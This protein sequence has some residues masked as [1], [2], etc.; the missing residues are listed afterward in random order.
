LVG[1]PKF[2]KQ[3]NHILEMV[4]L[5]ETS[6]LQK[7]AIGTTSPSPATT[8]T[9]DFSLSNLTIRVRPNLILSRSKEGKKFRE[10][11]VAKCHQ[12]SSSPLDEKTAKLYATAL[13]MYAEQVLPNHDVQSALCRVYDLFGDVIFDAPK[14]QKRIRDQLT[15]AALEICDRWSV[16]GHR[17]ADRRSHGREAS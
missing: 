7:V 14:N 17:L 6:D 16:V 10:F 4:E 11:G 5:L 3:P 15:E 12:L 13:Q 8:L 2:D 1:D 9:Q